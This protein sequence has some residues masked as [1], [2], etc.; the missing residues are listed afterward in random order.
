MADA[1]AAA[2][3]AADA[4]A[5][6]KAAADAEA[7]APAGAFRYRVKSNNYLPHEV[8]AVVTFDEPVADHLLRH[9]ELI[10]G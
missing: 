10:E 4:E 7:A 8:G 6:A 5:A 1:E 3:A 9:L 2:K